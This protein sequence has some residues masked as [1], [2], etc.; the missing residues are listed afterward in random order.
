MGTTSNRGYVYPDSTSDTQIW[1]HFE[2][3]ADDIDADVQ[4]LS[5]VAVGRPI[6]VLVQQS[7]QSF[8][9]SSA[10]ALTFGSG[11]ELADSDNYHDVSVNNT[12]VIPTRAG[13][14]TVRVTASFATP[15][16]A[17]TQIAVGPAKNGTRVDGQVV[18]RPDAASTA[19]AGAQ[20]TALI[21][22]N[23]SGDYFEGYVQ[24]NSGGSQ[25]TN[26]TVTLRS[27]LE[28]LFERP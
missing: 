10:G 22:C 1:A 12:R 18:T 20:S 2:T 7:A 27:T 9:S 26:A 15:G 8:G 25:N 28:V 16:S 13:W 11:S 4:N 19:G 24:Q 23:G 17:F 5:N 6:V 14:Y 21:Y 3:L